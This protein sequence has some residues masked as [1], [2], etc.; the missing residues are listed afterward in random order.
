MSNNQNSNVEQLLSG[1]PKHYKL[2][3][4]QEMI[5]YAVKKTATE[6]IKYFNTQPLLD[7]KTSHDLVLVAILKGG[8]FYAVDLSRNLQEIIRTET[9]NL[10]TNI[11]MQFIEATSYHGAHQANE[12]IINSKINP[13]D[14]IGKQ[15][16]LVDELLDNG[17][18]I[19]Q[20]V[21]YFN[22]LGLTNIYSSVA[23][24]KKGKPHVIQPTWIGLQVPDV[25]LVGYGL[26]DLGKYRELPI[27]C[28]IDKP[29]D[30]PKT[31]DDELLSGDNYHDLI[32]DFYKD[33]KFT[34]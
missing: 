12:L 14:F 24:I 6:I 21:K 19:S 34:S 15:I 4:D 25:W 23:F 13:E 8:A 32:K 10:P 22:N 30:I 28:F 16:I 1:L 9:T 26:D 3:A 33:T 2:L 31:K 11:Y 27:V 5:A 18:T 17:E 29:D 20:L 7:N